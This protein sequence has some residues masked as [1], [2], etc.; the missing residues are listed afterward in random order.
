MF[1][2]GIPPFYAEWEAF[3]ERRILPA[4]PLPII[5]SWQRCMPRLN[6]THPPQW[7]YVTSDTF[8]RLM[9]QH[10]TLLRLARPTLEDLCEYVEAFPLAL[11]LSDSTNCVLDML[12]DA[13]ILRLLQ[14]MGMRP[15]VFLNEGS[16]GTNA[17]AVA[18]L[19]GMP[20]SV[21]GAQ[22]YL[23]A[24]HGLYTAGA[25]MFTL[26]GSPLGAVMIV[27]RVEFATPLL[28]GLAHST[29]RLV[30]RNLH[31]EQLLNNANSRLNELNATLDTISEAVL[32]WDSK[33]IITRLSSKASLLL[34]LEVEHALGRS[35]KA[36]LH[37][38]EALE[39][40]VRDAR[41]IQDVEMAFRF[42]QDGDVRE[43]VFVVSL[44]IAQHVEDG[45]HTYILTLRPIEQVHQLVN[46]LVGAQARLSIDDIIGRSTIIRRLRH[47]ALVSAR[48]S[49]PVLLTG[50]P[51]VGKNVL[52]R[53]IHN[54]S[55]RAAGPFLTIN[56]R[57]VPRELAL[58][59]LLG[60]E[61]GYHN[62]QDGQP[63]KFELANG[64]TLYLDEI[65]ALNLDAQS[66]LLRVIESDELI[67]LS[68][69]RVIPVDVRVIAS[70][71]RD[72]QSMVAQSAF[73][74]DLYF[75]LAPFTLYLPS[76]RERP[77]DI[78]LLIEHTLRQ[79][80]EHLGR[81]PTIST[82]ALQMLLNYPWPGNVRELEA[83]LER[84]AVI[85]QKGL[86]DVVQLPPHVREKRVLVPDA[87]LTEPVHNLQEAEY[88]AILRAGRAAK[89]NMTQ[90]ARLLGIGRTTLWRRMKALDLDKF[91]FI[92]D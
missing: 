72:L 35:L 86:I 31:S 9:Q 82:E 42:G 51:G 34:G 79:I 69:R 1:S 88:L 84:A 26:I 28:L 85:S 15:G 76:L 65:D 6:P 29:A 32:E 5:H 44:R 60:Y 56:C 64:G 13:D 63:S 33:G 75:R 21:T 53:S 38:P 11:V 73:R 41:E 47:E 80:G 48:A 25:P 55:G 83:V 71:S 59:E 30:E 7:V 70:T 8:I 91:N 46:R 52:A 2:R 12:G 81:T 19:E 90:M 43:R 77:E 67:R 62:N 74:S 17:A 45:A 50:E 36:Q 4:V 39:E 61:S 23:S 78:P 89:G 49:A 92:E 54:S 68:G 58:G 14:D 18:L 10:D 57:A 87:P 16:V 3:T 24:L 22:H 20:V 37:L 66:A 27:T 40:A